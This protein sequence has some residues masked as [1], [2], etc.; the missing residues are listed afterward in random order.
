MRI[1]YLVTILLVGL[2]TGLAFAHVLESPA[3]TQYPGDL[4]ITLQTTL[5]VQWGPPQ[6]GGFLEPGAILATGVLAFG[7]R[8]ERIAFRLALLA[9][10]ALLL[11]FP[12]VFYALVE[13]SNAAFREMRGGPLPENWQALRSRWETGH[14][15]RF[16]LQLLAF[17][18]LVASLGWW[19]APQN[20]APD[21]G[22]RR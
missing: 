11:G 14:A 17:G 4:Y 1:G 7:V 6:I 16:G 15:L 5:Y 22:T 9:T 3:K 20:R 12:L 21:V 10:A 19:R 18:S 13:P 2:V 8:R